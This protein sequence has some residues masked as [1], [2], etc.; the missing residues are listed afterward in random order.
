[1]KPEWQIQDY[2]HMKGK[3]PHLHIAAWNF[4][5]E[6]G[7]RYL[8]SFAWLPTNEIQYMFSIH[9]WNIFYM[10]WC[11]VTLIYFLHPQHVKSNMRSSEMGYIYYDWWWDVIQN[12]LYLASNIWKTKVPFDIL[13]SHLLPT[14]CMIY[15][16]RLNVILNQW[17]YDMV[18]FYGCRIISHWNVACLGVRHSNIRYFDLCLNLQGKKST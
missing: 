6:F 12:S 5:L 4:I 18:H 1:M 11:I 2:Q 10:W 9:T 15:R 17:K 16:W 3:I 8:F 13:A 7:V 14:I